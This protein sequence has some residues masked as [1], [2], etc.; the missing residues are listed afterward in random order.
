MCEHNKDVKRSKVI[1]NER[2]KIFKPMM[3]DLRQ[4]SKLA[5]LNNIFLIAQRVSL[6]FFALFAYSDPWLQITSFMFTTFLALCYIYHTMPYEKVK[7]NRINVFNFNIA[8]LISYLVMNLNG[9]I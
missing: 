1:N 2:F 8:L 9:V 4:S 3:A 6:L 5:L 7:D